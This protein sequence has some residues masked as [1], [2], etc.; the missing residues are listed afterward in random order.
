MQSRCAVYCCYRKFSAH[1]LGYLLFELGDAG[2]NGGDEI[3]LDTIGEVLLL[4]AL[5]YGA[6][7]GDEVGAEEPTDL[8]NKIIIFEYFGR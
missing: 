8:Q 5:E 4:V 6:M 3:G 2:S 1:K 7:Q